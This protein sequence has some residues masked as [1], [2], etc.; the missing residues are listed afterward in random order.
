[1]AASLRGSSHKSLGMNDHLAVLAV[2]A[3]GLDKALDRVNEAAPQRFAP[4]ERPVI[5]LRATLD[6]EASQEVSTIE[7]ARIGKVALLTS[8]LETLRVD[9]KF[10]ARRSTKR[11]PVGGDDADAEMLVHA[12]Q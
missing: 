1:M 6:G 3:L 11:Y 7:L 5:E 8:L 2:K 9:A 10:D 12:V 4:E